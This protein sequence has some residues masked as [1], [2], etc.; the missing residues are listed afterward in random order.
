MRTPIDYKQQ[1]FGEE[2]HRLTND[3]AVFDPIGGA[4]LWQSRM[5]VTESPLIY[6]KS[7]NG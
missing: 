2:I 7:A 1:D 5:S 6:L 4:H 3:G